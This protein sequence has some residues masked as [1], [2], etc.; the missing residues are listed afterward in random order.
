MESKI[1]EE[2][3][4]ELREAIFQR[5][6]PKRF[7]HTVAV[8]EMTM[9]LCALFCPEHTIPMRAAALLHDITKELSVSEHLA[10]CEKHALT[11]TGEDA[12][13]HK[14]LHARTATAI[15]P[16]EFPRFADPLILNAVRWHTTGH[17]DMTLTEQILYFADYIDVTR[18]FENCVLLR[19]K[20]WEPDP[21]SMTFEDRL[22]HFEAL[23]LLSFGMTIKDLLT[24]GMPIAS[25][26]VDARNQLLIRLQS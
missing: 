26:T 16:S 2:L 23:L 14:T 24:E 12:L 22:R 10:L 5:M 3:L 21:S 20:F 6:S 25:D 13:A 7:A 8:E 4:D 15:I 9:R 17:R 1:T 18:T 19:Q 11:V